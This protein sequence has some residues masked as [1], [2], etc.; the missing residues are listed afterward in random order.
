MMPV[1]NSPESE[2]GF[3]AKTGFWS[4]STNLSLAVQLVSSF[5]GELDLVTVTTAVLGSPECESLWW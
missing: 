3:H 5:G 1:L 2:S 4:C